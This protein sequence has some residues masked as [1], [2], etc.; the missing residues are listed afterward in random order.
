MKFIL[1]IHS[2]IGVLLLIIVSIP[3]VLSLTTIRHSS[4][5]DEHMK[6]YI[7]NASYKNIHIYDSAGTPIY[8]GG[9]SDD[10]VIR[11]STFHIVGDRNGSLPKSLLSKESKKEPEISKLSGYSSR[12]V[13]INLTID[14]SL[15]KSAYNALAEK[16]YNGCI[17][18]IDYLTGEIKAMVSL[19]TVDVLN[20]KYIKDGA[21]INKA[22][23]VYPPGSV[24]KAVTVAA[25]LESNPMVKD[26]TYDCSGV[27]NHIVC[28]GRTAHGHVNLNKILEASCNCA[29][30][31]LANTML[32]GEKLNRYAEQFKLT[33]SDIAADISVKKG[34]LD[35]TDD[36]MWSANGQSKDMFSPLSVAMFYGAIANNG[37]FKELKIYQNTDNSPSERIMSEATANLLSEA[38]T[39][40][41]K[42]SG[43]KCGAFGKTGTAQLDNKPSHAWFV[44][45]LK[46]NSAPTY[47][48]V[49]FLEHGNKS[50]E[51]KSITKEF[52]NRCI[53]KNKI[54]A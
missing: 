34:S 35:A 38:M 16:G 29:I 5:M 26:Y 3:I 12:E 52:I 32:S 15:Q 42:K 18:V 46:D 10:D 1:K 6:E 17:V 45:S 28:N 8:D 13:D 37:I 39:P 48:I 2:V 41:C 30:S 9:F 24:F 31:Y 21:F 22:V 11:K 23:S 54:G 36:L 25:A 4:D 50:A 7:E 44:C 47:T 49:T 19:P 40:L 43:I 14:L 20:T 33:S 27:Q 53:I 51:A